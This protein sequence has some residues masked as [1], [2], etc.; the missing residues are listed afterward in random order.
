MQENG[1]KYFSDFLRLEEKYLSDK[2]EVE[3]GIEK[4]TNSFNY[5]W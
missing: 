5:S 1:I 3:K 4:N 2:I